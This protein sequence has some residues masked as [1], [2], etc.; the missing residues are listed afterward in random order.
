[1]NKRSPEYL[2]NVA[3][4]VINDPASIANNYIAYIPNFMGYT[5]LPRSKV[6]GNEYICLNGNR[7]LTIISPSHIG[8]PYGAF[9]RL[10]IIELTTQ[11]IKNKSN[12]VYIG[13]SNTEFLKILGKSCTGGN[14]GSINI[15]K[16]HI[17][18]LFSA[19][20][21]DEKETS[22]SWEMTNV[23]LA[24]K[25]S[26]LWKPFEENSWKSYIQIGTET[27]SLLKES[28]FPVDIRVIRAFSFYPLALD[29]YTYLIRVLP[30]NTPRSFWKWDLVIQM[31]GSSY[32]YFRLFK[33]D[34]INAFNWVNIFY[35]QAK[36]NIGSDGITLF[37]SSPH[38]PR[39][40]YNPVEK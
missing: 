17:K 20:F 5:C 7:R 21:H 11:V 15:T 9:T 39:K 1:M 33:R 12:E 24:N 36:F 35:P 31:F 19:S 22:S 6:T 13:K 25:A 14:N 26:I 27:F 4:Q 18:R 23:S 2:Y 32:K 29:V 10:V 3:N 38:V 30:S 28:A 37:R 40:M 34:L 8:L 16:D